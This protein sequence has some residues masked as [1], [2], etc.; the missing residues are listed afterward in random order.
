[1][2]IQ[3]CL[4]KSEIID[5]ATLKFVE[6]IPNESII[7]IYGKVC[8]TSSPTSCSISNY[9]IQVEKLFIISKSQET[10]PFSYE[11]G[12]LQERVSTKVRLDHRFMDLRLPINQILFKLSSRICENFRYFLSLQGFIEIHTPKIIQ[13]T[14][15]GGSEVFHTDY[16]G[17]KACL[18]Q[19]PQ[20]YKQLAIL[21]DMEKVFEIAPVFRAENSNTHRHLCEFTGLDLEMT[22]N[23]NYFEIID[24]V[25]KL[26]INI[27]KNLEENLDIH[28]VFKYF[29]S[30]KL[31]FSNEMH[32]ITFEESCRL[33][34]EY[35]IEQDNLQDFSAENEKKLGKII[36][37]RFKTDFYVIHRYPTK[38]R[39]FYTM[40]C[41]DNKEYSCSF[42]VFVRGEE[43]A[44][45]SQR[46]NGYEELKQSAMDHGISI[47]SIN[48]YLD[49]FKFG[50]FPHGGC[51]LGLERILMLYTGMSNIRLASLF[52]RDPKRLW[53]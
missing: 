37:E 10:L 29:N 41:R 20:L 12:I 49:A 15:E 40:P 28:H 11:E 6:G 32:I 18:A 53:P 44:S 5:K 51:G 34:K 47:E 25:Y 27:F 17:Q 14:S 13:G 1:M 42:D 39:P 9:E 21:G 8:Q 30:E 31:E 23:H 52:S 43:I 36:K 33:L 19:S 45:G 2:T 46:I 26:L 7:D 22:L 38:I 48:N 24:T 4:I 35:D 50:V 3:C 16:F